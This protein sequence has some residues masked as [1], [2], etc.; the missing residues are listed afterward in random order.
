M[1]K[2][3]RGFTL[4]ELSVLLLAL[5]LVLLGAVMYWQYTNRLRV[6]AVQQSTQAVVKDALLGYVYANHRLPCPAQDLNGLESCLNGGA[7]RKVGQV[8]WRTLGLP[9]PEAGAFRY[10]VYREASAQVETDRDL[11]SAKD[12]MKPLRVRTPDPR[13]SNGNAPNAG[14]PPVPVASAGLLGATQSGLLSA[15]LNAACDAA[16]APPC[17]L[18]GAGSVNQV[19]LC[20]ALNTSSELVAAPADQLGLQL[21]ATRRAMAFVVAAPGLLDAEGNGSAFDGPNATATDSNPTFAPAGAAAS[22]LYDDQILAVSA[23]ELFAQL[24]CASALAAVSHSHINAATGA[25]VLERA[26]YDYRDQ[27]YV[28]VRLAAA[29]VA[30]AA[31]GNASAVA[32]GVDAAQAV[33]SALGDS[34]AS[35]GARSFQIGLAAV[36][37]A[38]AVVGAATSILGTTQTAITLTDATATHNGFATRTTAIT[39]LA[40]SINHNALL[41]DAIGF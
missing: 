11:A 16:D 9:R 13:P 8:P 6:A 27:L 34:F 23:G 37:V 22:H 12:R 24:S 20:L 10:A 21:G 30:A 14:A 39:D 28:Q 5:G 15:P 26:L 32:A 40:I 36:G 17:P 19:D 38:L 4:I 2:H 31:A 35:A 29:D 25:L 3:V 1:N 33:V 7:L 41:A 18:I